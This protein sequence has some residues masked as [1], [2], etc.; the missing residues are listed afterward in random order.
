ML[1]HLW[2]GRELLRMES[3]MRKRVG[4]KK[5]KTVCVLCVVA[6]ILL[7]WETRFDTC[8][9]VINNRIWS[10]FLTVM[11]MWY[12]RIW[13]FRLANN[14]WFWNSSRALHICLTKVGTRWGLPLVR[15][16]RMI[17]W[18]VEDVLSF[19]RDTYWSSQYIYNITLK[20]RT[21]IQI[22]K[23]TLFRETPSINWKISS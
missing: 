19:T 13:C 8:L 23:T 7:S 14:Q 10:Y 1:V 11:V 16:I 22:L 12:L 15:W 2:L 21:Q 3:F 6:R 4:K 5:K 18:R 20:E 9:R 17:Y